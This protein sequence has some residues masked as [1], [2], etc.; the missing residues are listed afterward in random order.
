MPAFVRVF[1]QDP[2]NAVLAEIES[3]DVIDQPPP[4]VPLGAGFGAVLLVGEFERYAP[5]RPVEIF[6]GQDQ[7]AKL[8]GFG[9]PT[10]FSNHDGAVARKSG[11]DE[12]WNG[13]GFIWLKGKSFS[14]LI[15]CRVDNSAGEVTF[16]RLACLTGGAGPFAASNSDSVTFTLDGGPTTA[17]ATATG[18][19]GTVLA[20]GASYPLSNMGG[21]KLEIQVDADVSRIVTFEDSDTTLVD[22][23]ARINA[24]LAATV[25]SDSGGQL[26]SSSVILGAAGYIEIVGGDARSDLGIPTAAVAQVDTYTVNNQ[27]DG[28]Y[29]VRVATLVNGQ[30]VNYDATHVSST[31]T[32]TQL[33]DSLLA[34]LQNLSVPGVTF[35]SGAGDTITAT[36][37][38]NVTFT[39]SVEA[40][41]FAS[42]VTI[43]L[44]TAAVLTAG[45]GTGNV[46]NLASI[47][48]AEAATIIDAVANLSAEVDAS[49]LLRVCN[50]LTSGTGTIQATSGALLSILKFNTTDIADAADGSDVTI[51]AGTRV[52]GSSPA[53]VW[54]TMVDVDTGSGGG[55]FTVKVRPWVDTDEAL[56]NGIGTI[57]TIVDT[58]PDG[59]VVTNAAA[60]TRLSASQLDSRY[61][62]ALDAT[63]D[64]NTPAEDADFIVSAR[65]SAQI[66]RDLKSN[67]ELATESGMAPRKAIVRPLIGTSITNA[68]GST[69]QGVAADRDERRQYAFPGVVTQIPEIAEVG[70][71]G[72][73]G[74]SAD[75]KIQIGSD[76]FL[77]QVVSKLPPEENAGQALADTN[78]GSL[79]ILALEDAY[80]P[81]KG[82]S[83][84]T[85]GEYKAFKKA[86][87][88]APKISS[89]NGPLFQSDV[90][91]VDPATASNKADGSR[92]RLADFVIKTL[93]QIS[94]PF[95]KKLNTPA[96]RRSL[97]GQYNAFLLSL[98]TPNNPDTSRIAGFSVKDDST[99]DQRAAGIQAFNVKIRSYPAMLTIKL[100]VEVGTTVN[101]DEQ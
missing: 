62:R 88:T 34:E 58:L 95:V 45:K 36:G 101:I 78:A 56:A 21:K 60:V 97:T 68:Q 80:N 31:Q 51:P 41:P 94:Q 74:F 75:G 29:T 44:T 6:S 67:A 89:S 55:P 53:T 96:R 39:S 20:A 59:F 2:G 35:A 79:A 66:N 38:L 30:I 16:N 12:L 70:A 8:G 24:V 83:G 93:A 13:N 84:L 76:G 69:G 54:A 28:T 82:G 7:L 14:R 86:G 17:T 98:S 32:T 23:I 72:G 48:T 90:T 92:R 49:G 91:S 26:L 4:S 37:A 99:D 27:T 64:L 25:A 71:R 61:K 42:D 100:R 65:S 15:V 50:T 85:I 81:E 47:Q 40:E 11:G 73:T 5:E 33:R 63:L 3:V 9:F 18:A 22:V 87:I 46:Q 19:A 10:S 43:V 77:T 57:T 1:G 52:Q